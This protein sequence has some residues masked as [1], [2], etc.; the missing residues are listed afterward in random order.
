MRMVHNRTRTEPHA[1]TCAP[2]RF[3]LCRC[4][5]SF[6]GQPQRPDHVRDRSGERFCAQGGGSSGR[7]RRVLPVRAAGSQQVH[8]LRPRSR[9]RRPRRSDAAEADHRRARFDFHVPFAAHARRHLVHAG[10]TG[11]QVRLC[12]NGCRQADRPCHPRRLCQ[13]GRQGFQRDRC[14]HACR[15]AEALRN[16]REDA[17]GAG[18]GVSRSPGIFRDD[19]RRQGRGP[20][21]RQFVWRDHLTRGPHGLCREYPQGAGRRRRE[22]Q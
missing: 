21:V 22:R 12:R 17:G 20:S 19:L 9:R 18:R 3:C 4:G 11:R 7:A 10:E 2:P 14:A 8:G 15:G 6:R 13:H 1:P 16:L 5:P